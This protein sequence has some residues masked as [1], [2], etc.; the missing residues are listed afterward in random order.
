MGSSAIARITLVLLAVLLSACASQTRTISTTVIEDHQRLLRGEV[1][2]PLDEP[3]PEL[4][5]M[6]LLAVNDDMRAFLDKHIPNKSTS[7]EMKM[8]AILRGLFDEGLD[9]QYYNLA[10]Y[11]AEETFYARRGNCLSF[12]N[13][14]IALAREEGLDVSYQEVKVPAAWS[15]VGR[16]HYFSLHINIM[17]ELS[18]DRLRVV[19]FD[20]QHRSDRVRGKR[21]SD[22]T[23]A[24]Q[25]DNNM[26]VHYLEK[27]DLQL[28]FLH[29]RRAIEA[30]PQTGYFW[31]NLGTILRRAGDLDDAEEAYITAIALSNE[32]SAVSNLARLYELQ[33]KHELAA[34]Y[35]QKAQRFREKN[36]YYL[37]DL[38]QSAY[39]EGEYEAANKLLRS[40]INKRRDEPEFYRLYGLTWIQLGKPERAES[41]FEKAVH[42]STNPERSSLYEH[43]LRLLAHS[44]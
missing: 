29:S 43:K 26:A 30:R 35:A 38:A 10:T 44:E 8:A 7:D 20:V 37:Y 19:D 5:P 31:A 25:Y 1:L 23:A 3:L 39:Q 9:L 17:V 42:Y 28:A 27:G 24:A 13:L 33:G 4:E 15:A 40:A 11:T 34:T 36:P 41:S 6:E 22:Q 21:V 14:Y 12:T 16:R 32:P 18:R 2:F